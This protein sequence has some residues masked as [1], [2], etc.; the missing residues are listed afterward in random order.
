MA[1][2]QDPITPEILKSPSK[3][4]EELLKAASALNTLSEASLKLIESNNKIV[5]SDDTAAKKKK[6]LTE[7]EKEANRIRTQQIQTHAK[8][9]KARSREVVALQKSKLKLQETNK[10]V[11]N[12][13][14][15]AKQSMLA[16]EALKGSYNAI[17]K[18]LSANLIKWKQLTKVEREATLEGRK[19]TASIKA[20]R[21]ELSKLDQNTGNSARGVGKYAEGITQA[22]KSL[23]GAFGLVGGVM[24]FAAV[25]KSSISTV[26]KYTS[27]NSKLAS[28]L[29]KTN[30]QII[31]LT[32]SSK[33]YGRTTQFT[34]TQVAMLQTELAKLGF[35]QTE[36]LDSTEAV[37]NLAAA[38]G[39]ELGDAA[40][41][42]G[43]A[44]RAMGLEASE[45]DRVASVL[46]VSTTKTAASFRDFDGN[47]STILPVAKAFNFSIEDSVALFGKL[48]DAGF[49]ASSAATAT[50]NIL[51]NLADTNGK[52]A[53][54]IGGAVGNFDEMIDA[55]VKLDSQGLQLGE[56][57]ELTDKRSV[58]AFNQFLR[59][60]EDARTLRNSLID[61]NDELKIMVETRNAN[62]EG[63]LK[64]LSSAWDGQILRLQ[65]A[66]GFLKDFIDTVTAAISPNETLE[67]SAERMGSTTIKALKESTE[68]TE[69]YIE[70]L[71]LAA[72][73]QSDITTESLNAFTEESSVS[74]RKFWEAQVIV[75]RNL[76]EELKDARL[77]LEAEELAERFDINNKGIEDLE[78]LQRSFSSFTFGEMKRNADLILPLIEEQIK[79]REELELEANQKRLQNERATQKEQSKITKEEAKDRASDVIG[80][81]DI[82]T[83][84]KIR[85]LKD[86][87]DSEKK[88]EKDSIQ[89]VKDAANAKI[90]AA[91]K[92]AE[93][94]ID[95]Q[96]MVKDAAI[97]LTAQ[98]AQA[99]TDLLLESSSQ[100]RD[101][102]LERIDEQRDEDLERVEEQTNED[103]ANE[104][105]K[106]ELG[107][108]TEEQAAE[109]KKA[110]TAASEA[111]KTKIE[112]ES[113][114][115]SSA[116]KTKQAK[117][118]KAA[119]IAQIAINSATSIIKAF[120][121]LG[122]VG[123][124]AIT[125]FL[126]GA[127]AIQTATV[128]ATPI[129]KFF[130]G[131][132]SAPSGLISTAEKGSELV[133]PKGGNPFMT[134][135]K[136]T[137][138]SDLKG[139]EIVPNH[140]V[141]ERL[142]EMGSKGQS[143]NFSDGGIRQD[144]SK[145]IKA[146]KQ[147]SKSSRVDNKT[148][149]R[150]GNR[151]ATKHESFL[152]SMRQ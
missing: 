25:L 104:D 9:D 10:E 115:K 84:A 51:L 144:L 67:Q 78:K 22:A 75:G 40:R 26:V 90:L 21:A 18:S 86:R 72:K 82:I 19:L 47:L 133:I 62:L 46:A 14:V 2:I 94:R 149:T 7:V 105:E 27:Q 88:F 93:E 151:L 11:K 55:L 138:Y 152:S 35:T 143:F 136:Q 76:R 147:Q 116:I 80:F 34:A 135:D 130:K 131:T 83:E 81:E 8:L 38:T 145:L 68:S 74:N 118:E 30:S 102:E 87:L 134:P 15:V 140:K 56:T 146:T 99:I 58:A 31:E 28:V 50:R 3:Y 119:A 122:P 127:A 59:G 45:M 73:A 64:K 97:D 13:I 103:L 4:A 113:D 32:K 6:Q 42:A 24:A 142:A 39:S 57:L 132:K 37:L 52:L 20:Q 98:G 16:T 139:A 5:A 120:A 150:K 79:Q 121:Q 123:G 117:A 61:V 107:L 48:R 36:I 100:R 54:Q 66:D 111:E 1:K 125:P 95:I 91:K 71:E 110:I 41:V 17:S 85:E 124:A 63:S 53:K 43:S 70:G 148:T 96:K 114:R 89:A 60:A 106:V 49:D 137:F 101:E 69:E 33:E 29:G 129:P 44:L 141:K 23:I 109:R 128:L 92:E 77:T 65:R 126:V 108:Q 112:E 12:S